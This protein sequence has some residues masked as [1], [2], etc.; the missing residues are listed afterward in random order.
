M[1]RVRANHPGQRMTSPAAAASPEDVVQEVAGQPFTAAET[2]SAVALGVLALLISGLFGL[3]FSA[4]A[5]EHRLS[6]S[7]I[8]LAAMVEA[9]S[10]GLTT[11]LAGILL[12]PK[13]LRPISAIATL[14]VV[15]ADLATT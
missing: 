12:K 10:T 9:L 2:A 14:L 15:A 13:G 11:G 4:L 6:A 3:L 5:E 8:G 1:L 7:G